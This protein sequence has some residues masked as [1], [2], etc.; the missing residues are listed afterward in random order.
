MDIFLDDDPFAVS[1]VGTAGCIDESNIKFCGGINQDAG[2]G[3][4]L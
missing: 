1:F 4:G 3:P 2:R